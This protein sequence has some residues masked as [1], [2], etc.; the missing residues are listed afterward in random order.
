MICKRE[1]EI[2]VKGISPYKGPY[3]SSRWITEHTEVWV[4]VMRSTCKEIKYVG[5]KWKK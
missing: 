3:G 5:R 4:D 2:Q 1:R